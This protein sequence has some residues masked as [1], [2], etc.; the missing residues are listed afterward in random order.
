MATVF[1]TSIP[2]SFFFAS[3][4]KKRESVIEISVFDKTL[5]N[6]VSRYIANALLDEWNGFFFKAYDG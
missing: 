4:V 3:L 5:K 2:G 1:A 6:H